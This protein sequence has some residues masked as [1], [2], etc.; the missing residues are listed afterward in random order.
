[1]TGWWRKACERATNLGITIA[2]LTR[3]VHGQTQN[4]RMVKLALDLEET[5]QLDEGL[6]RRSDKL[7]STRQ[8]R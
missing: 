1:M 4:R 6:R 7:F 5:L 8:P 3:R 2:E